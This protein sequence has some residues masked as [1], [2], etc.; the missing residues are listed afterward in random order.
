MKSLIQEDQLKVTQKTMPNHIIIK[1]QKIR[2]NEKTLR[3]NQ[4]KSH[5]ASGTYLR[6]TAEIFRSQKTVAIVPSSKH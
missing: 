6:I 5:N 1:L 3:H 4:R 2:G